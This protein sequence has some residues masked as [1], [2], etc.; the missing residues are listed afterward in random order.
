MLYCVQPCSSG[1]LI[2]SAFHSFGKASLYCYSICFSVASEDII[3]IRI[4]IYKMLCNSVMAN[5]R[6]SKKS[7]KN[8]ISSTSNIDSLL[9]PTN[10]QITSNYFNEP[11]GAGGRLILPV[12]GWYQKHVACMLQ[13]RDR[14]PNTHLRLDYADWPKATHTDR[15]SP[16]GSRNTHYGARNLE[17]TTTRK[18][19]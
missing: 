9:A 18:I 15:S 14:L 17:T 19:E 2:S 13:P 8:N 5:A 10:V 7:K 16:V 11:R 4:Y 12:K 1:L 6:L 3:S